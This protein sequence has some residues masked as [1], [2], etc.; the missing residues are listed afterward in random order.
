MKK[1]ILLQV[2]GLFMYGTVLL[3]SVIVFL[4]ADE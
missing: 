4:R 3:F 1:I 2:D